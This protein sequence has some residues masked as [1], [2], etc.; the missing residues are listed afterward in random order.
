MKWRPEVDIALLTCRVYQLIRTLYLCSDECL[1][2]QHHAIVEI[3]VIPEFVA[4]YHQTTGNL[5]RIERGAHLRR[6]SPGRGAMQG[7]KAPHPPLRPR[8]HHEKVRATTRA[9][10]STR[11]TR[12]PNTCVVVERARR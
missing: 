10:V 5:G 2:S 1:R 6:R 8:A 11:A 12:V 7:R 3:S 4:L 9:E